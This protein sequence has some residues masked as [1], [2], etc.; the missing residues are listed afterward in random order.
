VKRQKEPKGCRICLHAERGF[1]SALLE[2]GVSP[3]A[4]ARRIGGTTRKALAAHRDRCMAANG[5]G[6]EEEE[7]EE[8]KE[9]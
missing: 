2:Q 8:E 3:R 9:E 1:I 7:E 5:A 4:I 6:D